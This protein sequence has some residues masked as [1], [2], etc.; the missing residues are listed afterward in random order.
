MDQGKLNKY[1]ED[2]KAY[3]KKDFMLHFHEPVEGMLK[4]PFATSG[5]E[6]STQVWDWGSWQFTLVMNEMDMPELERF[7][8]GNVLNFIDKQDEQGRIPIVVSSVDS[9]FPPKLDENYHYNIHKPVLATHVLSVCN[10]YNDFEWIKPYYT[11]IKKFISYYENNLKDEESGL[12]TMMDDLA[13]GMDNDP[14][15]FYK[16]S[17]S[18][19]FT[20]FNSL[21]YKEYLSMAELSKNLSQEE[22]Y[23]EY[24]D[25]AAALKTAIQNE[26]FDPIDGYFYSV[27]LSLKK[28]DKNQWLHSNHPRFWH[29]L[30]IKIK[31]VAGIM[32]LA[33]GIATEEQAKRVVENY[34][35][36]ETL[37]SEYGIRSLAKNEKM[38]GIYATCNPSCWLGPVWINTNYFLW[39]G[40][41]LY[42][43]HE[44]A[45]NLAKQTIMVMGKGLEKNGGFYEYYD[46][47]TGEGVRGLG[48][49]GWNF[50]VLKMIKSLQK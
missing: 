17:K 4:Y 15:V 6:Y 38:Y 19:G 9:F 5:I 48:M 43:Y 18:V 25:K 11:A 34:L 35:N 27:D 32:P 39:E 2:I 37:Y 42:G 12:F 22:D 8:K 31:T 3:I 29:T 26:C 30:P 14:A 33:F 13:I 41:K 28:I 50:L 10:R 49:H 24:K 47:E 45:D 36:K 44:L 7:Q 21:M 40:L 20:L 1:C 46:P 23:I 16:P